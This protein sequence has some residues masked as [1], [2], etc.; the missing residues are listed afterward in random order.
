MNALPT[1]GLNNLNGE[2]YINGIICQ[3]SITLI[4]I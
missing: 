4:E 1:D 2:S 3:H